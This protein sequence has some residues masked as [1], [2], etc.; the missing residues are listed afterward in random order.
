MEGWKARLETAQAVVNPLL[1]RSTA[2]TS[3][4]TAAV[5]QWAAGLQAQLDAFHRDPRTVRDAD[6]LLRLALSDEALPPAVAALCQD[7]SLQWYAV[8]AFD[9][10]FRMRWP[11]ASAEERTAVRKALI[12]HTSR[13]A[14]LGRQRLLARKVQGFVAQKLQKSLVD[15]GRLEVSET[16]VESGEGERE[17]ER[18]RENPIAFSILTRHVYIS[19]PSTGQIF[20]SPS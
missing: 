20:C 11:S 10:F 18:E 5:A 9:A 14:D 13:V 1:T 8:A 17:R 3:Q 4:G 6:E 19:G 12:A 2:P 15:C 16:E 7:F